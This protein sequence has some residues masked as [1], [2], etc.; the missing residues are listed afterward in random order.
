MSITGSTAIVTGASRGIGRAICVA[1]AAQGCQVVVNYAGSQEEA[2]ATRALCEEAGGRV[3]CHRADV[4]DMA[5]CQGLFEA[6]ADAF[7]PPS[8]LVNNAGITRD[9]LLMRM[10][11]ED[12]DRVLDVN[13]KGAFHCTKLAC[14]GMMKARYGRIVNISSVVGL[15]GNAG[16]ANYAAS[17]AGLIGLTKTAARELGGRGIT[18][19]AV[20]PG[21]IDTDMTRVLPQAVREG[22]LSSIPLG[23]LGAPEEVA[24]AV[25][26][27]C[28]DQAAY[29]TGQVLCVDGGM[30]I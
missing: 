20:A 21:F 19:N 6:C 23:R 8:V 27:L 14:R 26:F 1:L 7:G 24:Q 9:G 10:A 5:A 2:E 22:L 12:F 18:V 17:K 28:S 29:I 30:A 25:A 3:L 4:S 16:Q 11:E 15:T 13:L